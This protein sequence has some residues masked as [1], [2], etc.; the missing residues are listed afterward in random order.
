MSFNGYVP[1]SIGVNSTI[2][3]QIRA[4]GFINGIGIQ[5][6][7]L[8]G[9]V[10][11]EFAAIMDIV[12]GGTITTT[13]IEKGLTVC[14]IDALPITSNV[15]IYFQKVAPNSTRATGT[16]HV[17]MSL[18]T[19][20][21]VPRR[22]SAQQSQVATYELEVIA[23]SND[24][25]TAPH[26]ITAGQALAGSPATTEQFTLGPFTLNGTVIEC[27][28]VEID[29]G[30]DVKVE[31]ADGS[32]YARLVYVHERMPTITL[33]VPDI[34]AI[35]GGGFQTGT[36]IS[37]TTKVSLLKMEQGGTRAASGHIEC[38]IAEGLVTVEEGGGDG[39]RIDQGRIL[40]TPTF[41]GTNDIL[42]FG[43]AA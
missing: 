4:R 37:S 33:T 39:S 29:F 6:P 38:E 9:K 10:D 27:Q 5:R 35:T 15:D 20:L 23:S 8:D 32:P 30:I 40:I 19:G 2:I 21:L 22:I 12:P 26:S 25:T 16:N 13:A 1:Y 7:M 31:R 14:G 11:P 24:G 34:A 41:D 18:A 43:A 28:G 17:A 3:D 36:Q 42:A